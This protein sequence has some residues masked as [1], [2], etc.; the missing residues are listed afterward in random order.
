ME[1]IHYTECSCGIPG[2]TTVLKSDI[3]H[4]LEVYID[5][6]MVEEEDEAIVNR[7]WYAIHGKTQ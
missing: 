3:A 6:G 5:N 1:N 4:I 7:L 2:E